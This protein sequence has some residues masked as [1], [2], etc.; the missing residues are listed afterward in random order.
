[1]ISEKE[2]I[3]HLI[4]LGSALC[5]AVESVIFFFGLSSTFHVMRVELIYTL[6][7]QLRVTGTLLVKYQ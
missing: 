6:Y 7:L 2:G 3:Y 1:M 4:A 5:Q